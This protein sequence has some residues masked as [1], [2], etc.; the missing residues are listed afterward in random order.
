[1][2]ELKIPSFSKSSLV[3]H[4]KKKKLG[5]YKLSGWKISHPPKI[6]ENGHK[7]RRELEIFAIGITRFKRDPDVKL[8][9]VSKE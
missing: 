2:S 7:D 1:M 9:L 6:V 8:Q 5:N 4:K 3:I